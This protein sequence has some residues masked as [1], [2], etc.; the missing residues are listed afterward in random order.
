MGMVRSVVSTIIAI[1]MAMVLVSSAA[2]MVKVRG[3]K[4]KAIS[5]AFPSLLYTPGYA[6]ATFTT[7]TSAHAAMETLDGLP[8]QVGPNVPSSRTDSSSPDESSQAQAIFNFRW[9]LKHPVLRLG[10]LSPE[11]KVED[12]KQ[13]R[14]YYS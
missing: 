10:D 5:T 14:L 6:T 7:R 3:D 11:V 2:K 12:L 13:V 1:S 9:L 4:C 8:I